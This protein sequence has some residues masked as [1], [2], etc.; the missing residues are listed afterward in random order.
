MHKQS[1]GPAYWDDLHA[2]AACSESRLW[3]RH[4]DA[5]NIAL[6]RRWFPDLAEARVLKTDLFDEALTDGLFPFLCNKRASIVGMDLS[7][8]VA[9]KAALGHEGLVALAG[10]VR[11]LPFPNSTFDVV[12][13][14]STLDHFPSEGELI[15]SIK[16]LARVIKPKGVLILTLDNPSNPLV[17]L[18]NS[19]IGSWLQHTSLIPYYIGC[20]CGIKELS[21]HLRSAG[22]EVVNRTAILHCPR[23]IAVPLAKIMGNRTPE[24][25]NKFLRC[26]MAFERFERFRT[27]YWTGHF[28]AA[29]ARHRSKPISS[30]EAQPTFAGG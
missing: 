29:L 19:P 30:D 18:R 1:V 26:L 11:N 22:M 7:R 23:A 9:K 28:V 2:R 3:R 5:V 24:A 13:S 4:S 6:L 17:R 21:E 10:D 14:N 20:T 16:E 15:V 12:V 8:S 25:H 27:R